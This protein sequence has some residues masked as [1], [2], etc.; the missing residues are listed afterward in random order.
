M[1]VECVNHVYTRIVHAHI[2][3]DSIIYV[4][5]VLESIGFYLVRD[6]VATCC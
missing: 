4:E 6:Y 3:V 5:I 2:R 1:H